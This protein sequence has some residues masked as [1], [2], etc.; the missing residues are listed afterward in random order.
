[1]SE[2]W[3]LFVGFCCCE[4]GHLP[5]M[6]SLNS[7]FN[8]RWLAWQVYSVR[9]VVQ[10]Y[11]VSD[12]NASTMFQIYDLRRILI[13]FYIKVRLSMKG[14]IVLP[15]ETV[16]RKLVQYIWPNKTRNLSGHD[17]LPVKKSKAYGLVAVCGKW[18]RK[19]ACAR[20]S[21]SGPTL[22]AEHWCGF[23]LPVPWNFSA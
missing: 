22:H 23:R 18:D 15:L 17:L 8:Q 1:M 13:T 21:W 5:R 6:L 3:I 7:A 2:I 9:Y 12:N 19:H 14:L 20:I 10:G 16:L 11:S 4:P